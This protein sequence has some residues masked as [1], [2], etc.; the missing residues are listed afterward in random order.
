MCGGNSGDPR[1][2][3]TTPY[4]ESRTWA[5]HEHSQTATQWT[6]IVKT[7][8]GFVESN[9]ARREGVNH[10]LSQIRTFDKMTMEE[11]NACLHLYIV[12]LL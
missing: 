9:K 3:S 6:A 8:N 2:V 1:V 7:K 10:I 11:G 5:L 12:H 4:T